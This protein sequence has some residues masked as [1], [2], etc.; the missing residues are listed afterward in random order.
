MHF[1]K[2]HVEEGFLQNNEKRTGEKLRTAVECLDPGNRLSISLVSLRAEMLPHIKRLHK[3]RLPVS[4]SD[5]YFNEALQSSW[6]RAAMYEGTIAGALIC[7][8]MDGG[9]R[10]QSLV[11]AVPRRGIGSKLL[12][13]LCHEAEKS[14]I[15]KLSLHVHVRNE[16]AIALYKMLG[17][18]T[19]RRKPN[20]YFRSAA[21]LEEPLD[22]LF[23]VLDIKADSEPLAGPGVSCVEISDD[24]PSSCVL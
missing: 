2:A 6:S 23:M 1:L 16:A 13:N 12:R 8:E 5:Q 3:A 20:Y 24:E 22:A 17:F 9:L 11:A 14:G 15:Q 19:E 7:K 18:R 4:Y 21:T 10:V